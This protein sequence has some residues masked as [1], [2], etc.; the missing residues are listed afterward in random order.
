MYNCVCSRLKEVNGFY[1]YDEY[2]RFCHMIEGFVT[3]KLLV[4]VPVDP[5]YHEGEMSKIR[6]IAVSDSILSSIAKNLGLAKLIIASEHETKLGIKNLES[7]TAC[8]FEAVL[9]AYFLDGKLDF[10]REKLKEIFK[11]CGIIFELV[12]NFQGAPIQGFIKNKDDKIILCMTLRQ[13]YADIFWFT[14]F[15]EIG[16]ILNNDI[17]IDY[18]IENTEAEDTADNF[19]KEFLINSDNYNKYI[20]KKDFSIDSIKKFSKENNIK[21]FILIGRLQKDKLLPYNRYNDL[22]IRYKWAE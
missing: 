11:E 20:S 5:D 6:S 9:G 8:T 14:L 17:K 7:V 15:H 4:E 18:Y 12:K 16:H 19:A 22:K 10:L 21:E 1:D 13:S 2:T 3:N